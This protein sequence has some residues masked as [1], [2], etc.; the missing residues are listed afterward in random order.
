MY[1][2][3]GFVLFL[4][5]PRENVLR[6]DVPQEDVPWEAIRSCSKCLDEDA[7]ASPQYCTLGCRQYNIMICN[8]SL[9]HCSG[10][11]WLPLI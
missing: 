11:G 3:T 6:E 4:Q 2:L 7:H 9:Q 8:M 10:W 5:V 1:S